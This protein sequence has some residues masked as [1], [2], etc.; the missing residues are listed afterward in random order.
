M[1]HVSRLH[2]VA[3]DWLFDRVNLKPEIHIKYV[4]TKNH[5]AD[6]QTKANFTRDEWDHLLCLFNISLEA[7]SKR[8]RKRT[9]E[10]NGEERLAARSRPMMNLV[11]KTEAGS[12]T[13]PS[14]SA[15]NSL[16]SLKATSHCLV[17]IASAERPVAGVLECGKQVQN[18]TRVR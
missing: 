15:S 8:C 5:L 10:G 17:L 9:Q 6:I 11:S 2:R 18:W 13:V 16:G 12:S 4:D 3:L 14:S 7:A 1:R